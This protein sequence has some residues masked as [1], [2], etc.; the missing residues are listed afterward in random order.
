MPK[1]TKSK[2]DELTFQQRKF[3]TAYL[4]SGVGRNA[5]IEAGYSKKSADSMASQLLK[6]P[7]IKKAIEAK[8]REFEIDFS[9]HCYI[10]GYRREVFLV[11]HKLIKFLK[12]SIEISLRFKSLPINSLK[13]LKLLR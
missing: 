2:R 7:K 6:L 8:E 1:P 12:T 5:A 4:K 11:S 13:Y 10:Y 3:E 9:Y